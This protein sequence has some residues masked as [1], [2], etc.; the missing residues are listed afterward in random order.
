MSVSATRIAL[1]Y[2]ELLGTYGDGG[3]AIVLAQRLRWRRLP[4]EVIEVPAGEPV[5]ES[6]DI[7]LLGGG[8]DA[9][10]VL[11][12]DGMRQTKAMPR[13][14]NGGAVVLAVCAGYQVI[15]VTFPSGGGVYDGLGLVDVETRRSF[16][17]PDAPVPPRAV[18][19]IV[20]EPDPELGL[21]PLL[22]Y[23]NHGGRTRLLPGGRGSPLG[24]VRV[25][26]GN[27][28]DDGTDGIVYRHVVGTY[29]HGPVLAQNPA[30]ADLLLTWIH[31][32]L[33]PLD[34]PRE[35]GVL[36]AARMRA[37]DVAPSH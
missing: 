15:G 5:P 27:G 35:V 32:T 36:R 6:C 14:V 2:P 25:G 29:L 20:V 26:I 37:L 33:P 13:A 17:P 3:N 4:A 31:G 30:L 34:G 23:E 12:A 9:P 22:G 10:Q 28:T 24:R 16:G 18:G 8:E 7:Y 1:V 21:P 19:D 11:A